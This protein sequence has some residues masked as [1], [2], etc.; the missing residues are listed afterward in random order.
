MYSNDQLDLEWFQN[1][2]LPRLV[3][4]S[5]SQVTDALV[6]FDRGPPQRGV[7]EPFCSSAPH[8][9]VQTVSAGHRGSTGRRLPGPAAVQAAR[10][11]RHLSAETRSVLS[12]LDGLRRWH[13]RFMRRQ[14]HKLRKRT[15]NN[16]SKVAQTYINPMLLI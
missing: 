10:P 5:P 14:R 2:I 3:E 4:L 7:R 13:S 1:K 16:V 15:K 8:G 6:S 12:S 11:A 9:R